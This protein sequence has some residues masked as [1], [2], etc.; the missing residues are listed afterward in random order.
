MG[1]L[2][3]AVFANVYFRLACAETFQIRTDEVF[4]IPLSPSTFNLSDAESSAGMYIFFCIS[5]ELL[6]Y[7][8]THMLVCFSGFF[9]YSASL[10]SLPD[11]PKWIHM[12]YSHKFNMG[13]LYGTPPP[14]LES[15]IEVFRLLILYSKIIKCDSHHLFFQVGSNSF[16]PAHI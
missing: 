16:K 1:L 7:P 14:D 15:T 11:L 13:F 10:H 9:S 6:F 12:T 3:F 4:T 2:A 8:F 5:L